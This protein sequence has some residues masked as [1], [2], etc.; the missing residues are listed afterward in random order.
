MHVLK[1]EHQPMIFAE[2]QTAK[3]LGK[4]IVPHYGTIMEQ[5]NDYGINNEGVDPFTITT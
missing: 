1:T 2:K 3:D 5:W 4:H